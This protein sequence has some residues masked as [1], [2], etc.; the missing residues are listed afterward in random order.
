MQERGKAQYEEDCCN[1]KEGW[2]QGS[3]KTE[4]KETDK[5]VTSQLLVTVTSSVHQ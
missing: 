2:I 5:L 4:C 1:W 3:L